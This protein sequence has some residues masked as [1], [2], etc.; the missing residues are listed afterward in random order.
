MQD[1]DNTNKQTSINEPESFNN[2]PTKASTKPSRFKY[3]TI[4]LITILILISA[5]FIGLYLQEKD[6]KTIRSNDVNNSQ[7]STPPASEKNENFNTTYIAK[8]GKFQLDLSETYA[9]IVKIDGPF[10]GGPATQIQVGQEMPGSSNVINVPALGE[11]T[12]TAIPAT[13]YENNF[14]AFLASAFNEQL[15]TPIEANTTFDGV[16]ADAYSVDGLATTE[17]YV[18]ENQGIYYQVSFDSPEQENFNQLKNDI[19]NGFTFVD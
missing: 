13:N 7:T 3:L 15:S 14:E 9:I 1:P 8:V 18:F 11:I 2:I 6:S 5:T 10:E 19:I 4:V 12:L 17:I 16:Q